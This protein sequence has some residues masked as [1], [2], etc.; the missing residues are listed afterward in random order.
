MVDRT[1]DFAKELKKLRRKYRREARREFDFSQKF[2]NLESK[3][4]AWGRYGAFLE[5]AKDVND[6][7]VA[8]TGDA[9][10]G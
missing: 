5:A 2:Q 7:L 4:K 9:H 1:L 8:V 3:A 6:L 10:G